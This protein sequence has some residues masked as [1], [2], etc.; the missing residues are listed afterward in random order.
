MK[1]EDRFGGFR[2]VV[3][4]QRYLRNKTSLAYVC[5][6]QSVANATHVEALW[7]TDFTARIA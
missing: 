6:S 1:T 5:D 4:P 2:N 3:L 7:D